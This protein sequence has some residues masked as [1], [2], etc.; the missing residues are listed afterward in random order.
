MVKARPALS[1]IASAIAAALGAPSA[2]AAWR[3][4]PSVDVQETWTDNVY[5]AQAGSE[6]SRLVTS[7]APGF[8]L[9]NET[10]SVKFHANYRL[11]MYAYSGERAEGG[12]ASNNS[13][14]TLA[15]DVKAR[16]IN[17]LL[18]FEGNATINQFAA[19]AF[20]PQVTP[21]TGYAT[22]N[23]N[24]VR[25]Y[26]VSPYLKRGLGSS[27]ELEV[28]YVHDRVSSDNAGFGQSNGDS[29]SAVL[30]SGPSFRKVAWNLSA[31][32]Q[33]LQD[34]IAPKS[35]ISNTSGL[36]Q[37]I[38]SNQFSLN[39]TGGYD[40]YD[41][42]SSAGGTKGASYTGGF[43]WAPSERT[44]LQMSGGHRF[45]GPSY[46]LQA[47]H[48]SRGTVWNLNYNDTISNSRNQFTL[49]QTLNTGSLLDQLFAASIPDP[50]QRAAAVAAYIAATGL[51]ASLPNAV[52]Y[53]SN[54]FQLQKQFTGSMAMKMAHSS[55]LFSITRMRR[56]AVSNGSVDS[57]LL[58]TQNFLL[59]DNTNQLAFNAALNYQLGSR[60]TA[61]LSALASKT[62]SLSVDR[63]DHN[64]QLSLYLTRQFASKLSGIAEV[65][66]TRGTTFASGERKYTE[67][68][69][70]V[71][72]AMKF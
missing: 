69:V 43:R 4:Q 9:F 24:E 2:H 10:P 12:N 21:G 59:N 45:Y 42:D 33:V 60:T 16:V 34:S 25:T 19:S 27:A 66:R 36:L 61:T 29:L 23:R 52:N 1:L 35:T 47:S 68:A 8:T 41:Y 49:P 39:V 37:F 62:E 14:Q 44:S 53:F 70:S 6:Q 13:S 30:A 17:D 58:G 22:A 65:R 54:R 18:F 67:N 32:H 46:F 7:L 5:Q 31:M 57:A 56:E 20:G 50:V 51:P 15:A 28:R 38:L 40:K 48:R 71:G 26:R 55:G 11:N 3:F 63:T 72:L 64:R